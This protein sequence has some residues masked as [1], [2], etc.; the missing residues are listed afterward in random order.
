MMTTHGVSLPIRE[1][2]ID[3]LKKLDKNTSGLPTDWE[4]ASIK[5]LK[6]TLRDELISHQNYSCSYC[7]RE[8]STEIGLSELDHII[9]SSLAP[10]FTFVRANLTLTCKR[11]NSRKKA[12]NP[13]I[14][15]DVMLQSIRNYL[16]EPRQ[17]LWIHPYL[18]DYT[19]HIAIINDA[20]YEPI[21]KSPAGSAVIVAC[22]LDEMTAVIE[23]KKLA[24]I[25]RAKKKWLSLLRLV[26][27]FPEKP[28]RELAA[29]LHKEYPDT[30]L[31]EFN[32]KINELRRGDPWSEI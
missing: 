18:H 17:Y 3:E 32:R 24:L 6:D 12:H 4:K 9:P 11:C 19:R 10:Q 16:N 5:I 7:K 2:S 26:G 31:D 22:G 13:T 28:S 21:D 29:D 25:K 14:Y 8:I 27:A 23:K 30:P 15:A 20:V 1:W